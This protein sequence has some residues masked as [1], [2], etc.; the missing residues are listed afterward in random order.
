MCRMLNIIKIIVSLYL[1]VIS[2]SATVTWA[3]KPAQLR[4]A[5]ASNFLTTARTIGQQFERDT[6]V[7]VDFSSASSGKIT[8]QIAAGAPYDLFLSADSA[9]PQRLIELGLAVPDSQAIY[10]IG[11]LALV[12]RTAPDKP[13]NF[14]SRRMAIANPKIAPYGMAA[15]Q[16]L[17]KGNHRPDLIYGENI[18]QVWHFFQIGTVPYAIVA[19]SQLFSAPEQPPYSLALPVDEAQL[20][21]ALVILKRSKQP[22]IAAQFRAFLLSDA[23]QQQIQKAGYA[24][25]HDKIRVDN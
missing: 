14:A 4:V 18:N 12:S 20:A 21:Q 2:V 8:T 22:Q 25:R 10:A 6:G 16:W 3:E 9:R 23:I 11:Q 5:V 24:V 15:Q 1:L 13:L 17:N 7:K 19:Q